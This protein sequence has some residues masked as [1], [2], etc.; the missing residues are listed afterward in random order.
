MEYGPEQDLSLQP[1]IPQRA[2]PGGLL[3]PSKAPSPCSASPATSSEV[4]QRRPV[5][6]WAECGRGAGLAKGQLAAIRHPE[7]WCGVSRGQGRVG[8]ALERMLYPHVS[9]CS[10]PFLLETLS[11]LPRSD[12]RATNVLALALGTTWTLPQLKE[13][14]GLP[15]DLGLGLVSV[16]AFASKSWDFVDGVVGEGDLRHLRGSFWDTVYREVAV[17]MF[18]S[19]YR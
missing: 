1:L 14:G 3:T 16:S 19:E 2:L 9:L 4:P 18:K 5:L 17:T 8:G 6:P 13:G 7:L 15:S 12:V 10:R 11:I